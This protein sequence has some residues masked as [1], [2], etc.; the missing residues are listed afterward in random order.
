MLGLSYSLARVPSSSPLLTEKE[1][2]RAIQKQLNLDPLIAKAV[3]GGML[4]PDGIPGRNTRMAYEVASLETKYAIEKMLSLRSSF[5]AGDLLKVK[6]RSSSRRVLTEEVND[7]IV[8]ACQYWKVNPDLGRTIASM[9]SN[10]DPEAYNSAGGAWG[11]FQVTRWAVAQLKMDRPRDYFNPKGGDWRDLK[12]NCHVG[13][14]Y[15]KWCAERAKVSTMT[16]DLREW[17]DIYGHYNM[18][19]GA[20]KAWKQGRF[21]DDIV[22]KNW[23]TQA[24]ALKKGG[25]EQYAQNVLGYIQSHL[26]G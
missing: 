23:R 14:Y 13:V 20:Y 21:K 3:D 16:S 7:A 26:V 17:A 1:A 22:V 2:V 8:A 10:F 24:A 18:G 12:F 4:E 15:I 25:V 11:L 5:K 9:E 19:T 6:S